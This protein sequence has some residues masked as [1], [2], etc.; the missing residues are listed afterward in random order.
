MKIRDF[1]DTYDEEIGFGVDHCS[2]IKQINKA[3]ALIF[4]M[5]DY[6]GLMGYA[7]IV[8][9]GSCFYLPYNLETAK[10][11]FTGCKNVRVESL[12]YCQ[13]TDDFCSCG[14]EAK[15]LTIIKT[16]EHNPLPFNEYKKGVTYGFKPR[17]SND[18]G[19]TIT[20][21]Y[22]DRSFTEREDVLTLKHKTISKLKNSV[23]SIKYIYKDKTFGMVDVMESE[24]SDSVI[25]SLFPAETTPMYSRYSMSGCTCDCIIVYGKKRYIPYQVEE[26]SLELDTIVNPYALM[27][28]IKANNFLSGEKQNLPYYANHV[29]LLSD[30]LK[31]EKKDKMGSHT[32]A[33][34]IDW[35]PSIPLGAKEKY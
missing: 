7:T 25:H 13:V 12:G 20:V 3:L 27:L 18:T 1:L 2:A 19:K 5:G 23:F 24:K 29:K 32:G 6:M 11:A 4:P 10:K 8:H 30:F 35:N 17:S 9:C 15:E 28:A 31:Q 33:K 22:V 16:D 34:R 21:G 26:Q 14:C